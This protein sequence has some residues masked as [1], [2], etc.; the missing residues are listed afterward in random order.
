MEN[1]DFDVAMLALNPAGYINYADIVLPVAKE[2]NVGIIAIKVVRDLKGKDATAKELLEYAWTKN[3]VSSA[4]TGYY[5]L[6]TLK[7]NIK[8]AIEYGENNQIS[9]DAR[10]L[11]HRL[12]SYAGPHALCWAK[13]GYEDG[14]IIV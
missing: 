4:L 9:L 5:G 3:H 7:E 10:E 12:V 13:P 1:L 6:N 11:E 8:L 2:K 14:G